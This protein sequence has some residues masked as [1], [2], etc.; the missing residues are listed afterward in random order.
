MAF[1]RRVKIDYREYAG[2]LA[3]P[4]RSEPCAGWSSE[5]AVGNSHPSGALASRGLRGLSGVAIRAT[6][7]TLSARIIE[8]GQ[9]DKRILF[10]VYE[11]TEVRLETPHADRLPACRCRRPR[12]QRTPVRPAAPVA[13]CQGNIVGRLRRPGP[14]HAGRNQDHR[15]SGGT[16]QGRRPATGR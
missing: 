2:S 16:V 7:A 10:L 9:C 8:R 4:T 5:R 12:G 13:G 6:M 14:A 3:Q 11:F 1:L 15:L